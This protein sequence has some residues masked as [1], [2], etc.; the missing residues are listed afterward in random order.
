MDERFPCSFSDFELFSVDFGVDEVEEEDSKMDDE[1]VPHDAKGESCPQDV[2][3]TLEV[4]EGEEVR[5]DIGER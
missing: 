5:S 3:V 2:A 1:R 4:E